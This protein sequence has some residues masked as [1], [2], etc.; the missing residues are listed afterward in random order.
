MKDLKKNIYAG[1]S[2]LKWQDPN[3]RKKAPSIVIKEI[4][5]WEFGECLLQHPEFNY[6]S[7]TIL[8]QVREHVQLEN[9]LSELISMIEGEAS[10]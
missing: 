7:N 5:L 3:H 8:N 6:F 9:Y 2:K 1:L 10:K 4:L